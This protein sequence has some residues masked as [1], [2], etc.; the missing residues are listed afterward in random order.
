MKLTR[1]MALGALVLACGTAAAQPAP[2]SHELRVGMRDLDQDGRVS[3]N[4]AELFAL[5]DFLAADSDGD[6]ALTAQE[7][8]ALLL[9]D[10]AREL[11]LSGQTSGIR[12]AGGLPPVGFRSFDADGDGV[13]T[14][15][16]IQAV[17]AAEFPSIDN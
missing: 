6:G 11:G 2:A 14:W 13:V 12:L 15:R 4:E 7:F 9:P 10:I 8:R 5:A 17:V 3:R 1:A 16:E